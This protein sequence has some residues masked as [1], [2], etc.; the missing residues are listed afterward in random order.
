MPLTTSSTLNSSSPN[1]NQAKGK[2]NL[3]KVKEKMKEKEKMKVAVNAIRKASR[4]KVKTHRETVLMGN[5]PAVAIR[6]RKAKK[7]AEVRKRA[8]K[9]IFDAPKKKM[10][11]S[12]AN[13]WTGSAASIAAKVT[14]FPAAKT[15]RF[16][17]SPC[18]VFSSA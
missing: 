3:R 8:M 2:A 6:N 14:V 9:T 4:T 7:A 10:V 17:G 15:T 1:R 18:S 11:T 5:N 16:L 13:S 12:E